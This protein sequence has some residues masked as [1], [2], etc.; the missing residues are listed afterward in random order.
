M[1][2]FAQ[3]WHHNCE[4]QWRIAFLFFLLGFPCFFLMMVVGAFLKFDNEAYGSSSIEAAILVSCIMGGMLLFV[5]FNSSTWYRSILNRKTLDLEVE[6]AWHMG[7]QYAAAESNRLPYAWHRIPM[8]AG[9]QLPGAAA[10]V[11]LPTA[12]GREQGAD[13][14]PG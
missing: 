2:T 11:E 7:L 3:H 9:S 14:E 10:V 12:L 4:R 8:R 13:P 6:T 5:G 1:R